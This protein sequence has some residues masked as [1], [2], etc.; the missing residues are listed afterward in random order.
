MLD[1]VTGGPKPQLFHDLGAAYHIGPVAEVC[2][3]ADIIVECTGVG[4]LVFEAMQATSPGGIVCFTGNSSGK[5]LLEA[6]LTALSRGLVLENDVVFGTVNAN[7]RHY[8][9]AVDALA[10]AD[11]TWLERLLTR[12]VSLDSWREAVYRGPDDVKTVIDLTL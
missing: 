2:P 8:Q 12:R 1:R 7:R 9:Q 6:N 11:Y 4:Q 3:H 5:R 10:R